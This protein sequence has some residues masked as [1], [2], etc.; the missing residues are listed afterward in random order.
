[1]IALT[2]PP[3]PYHDACISAVYP[4][5]KRSSVDRGGRATVSCKNLMMGV[6]CDTAYL[7]FCVNISSVLYEA[8]HHQLEPV[9]R[10]QKQCCFAILH[11]I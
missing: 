5:Y 10:S 11:I 1:M 9:G 4:S 2:A 3:P 7:V 8:T 6:I